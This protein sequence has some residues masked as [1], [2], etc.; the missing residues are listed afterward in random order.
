MAD[1]QGRRFGQRYLQLLSCCGRLHWQHHLA[2]IRNHNDARFVCPDSPHGKAPRGVG[3]DDS[4]RPI[5]YAP[6]RGG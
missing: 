1:D 5:R 6:L 3:G 2:V 4:V